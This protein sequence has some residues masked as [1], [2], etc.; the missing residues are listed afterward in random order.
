MLISLYDNS[1]LV[2]FKSYKSYRIT[3][4]DTVAEIILFAG[5]SDAE[6]TMSTKLSCLH[7][8]KV[9]LQLLTDLIWFLVVDFKSFQTS[10]KRLVLEIVV[11]R[12]KF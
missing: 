2:F 6:I 9:L 1:V 11:A 7:G 5:I 8:R 10:D 3:P 12:K 4:S